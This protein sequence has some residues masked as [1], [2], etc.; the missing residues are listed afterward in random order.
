[1]I[2]GLLRAS[3]AGKNGRATETSAT[4]SDTEKNSLD[5]SSPRTQPAKSSIA[6]SLAYA[7]G[8]PIGKSNPSS[9]GRPGLAGM[10]MRSSSPPSTP[11]IRAACATYPEP[12]NSAVATTR[13]E[14]DA[15][16][17]ACAIHPGKSMIVGAK[18]LP[19]VS[20]GQI[21]IDDPRAADVRALLAVHL[22]FARSQTPPED[23]HAMDVDDLLDPAVTFFSYRAGGTLLAVGALKELD[24][25]HAEIK[26]MHTAQ[27]ARGRGVGR[28]MLEHLIAMASERGYRRLSLETGSMESFASARSLYARAGFVACGPFG[29]YR[30]SGNSTYMTLSLA[31]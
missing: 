11:T 1:M 23:A 24:A 12:R 2:P 25:H 28:Q 5:G 27:A 7:R 19:G 31:G 14:A 9:A 20:E 6:A 13:F 10:C 22:T 21:G 3:P 15:P 8:T 29:E 30:A 18:I 16:Q 4:S 17:S 26:S